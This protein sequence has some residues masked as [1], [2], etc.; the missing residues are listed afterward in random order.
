M[1]DAKDC[2]SA[3]SRDCG[4]HEDRTYNRHDRQAMPAQICHNG[5]NGRYWLAPP[6]TMNGD[7][8]SPSSSADR[9]GED[10]AFIWRP[11]EDRRQQQHADLRYRADRVPMMIPLSRSF[12]GRARTTGGRRNLR[13]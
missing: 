1:R 7:Q 12:A 2:F 4:Q 6:P 11:L 3:P 5:T 8:N 10:F 9:G 13:R